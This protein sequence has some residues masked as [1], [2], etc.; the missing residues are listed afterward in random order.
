MANHTVFGT[1]I[2][3]VAWLNGSH[4]K[5]V[6]SCNFYVSFAVVFAKLYL[7]QLSEAWIGMALSKSGRF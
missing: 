1:S 4:I 7:L 5:S 6:I 2:R 3:L